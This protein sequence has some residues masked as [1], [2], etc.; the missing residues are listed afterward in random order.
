[1]QQHWK[2]QHMEH[3][4]SFYSSTTLLPFNASCKR[5]WHL[6]LQQRLLGCWS[7]C[8]SALSCCSCLH[9]QQMSLRS[10]A[11][12]NT[13]HF[14]WLAAEVGQRRGKCITQRRLQTTWCTQECALRSGSLV[15]SVWWLWLPMCTFLRC[16]CSVLLQLTFCGSSGGAAG[17]RVHL[18]QQQPCRQQRH[19]QNRQQQG[20]SSNTG[21]SSSCSKAVEQVGGELIKSGKSRRAVRKVASSICVLLCCVIHA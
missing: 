3:M 17:L 12:S 7:G 9:W 4:N 5:S 19:K 13:A 2:Q 10:A 18:V 6:M 1:M 16:C 14:G 11:A 8:S 21:S 15:I 20:S